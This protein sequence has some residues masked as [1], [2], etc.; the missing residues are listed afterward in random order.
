MPMKRFLKIFVPIL[1]AVTIVFSIGWY[2]IEYDPSFTRDILLQQARRLEESGNVDAAVWFYHLAYL[3]S[4]NDDSVAIELAEKFQSIGNYSKAEYTLTKAIEDG[5][6]VDLYTALCKIYMEQGKLR[7]AVRLL[8]NVSNPEIKTAL[9]EL[10]PAPPAASAASGSY[11]QYLSV[12]LSAPGCQIYASMGSEYPSMPDDLYTSPITLPGGDTILYAVSVGQNG[13]VSSQ[14]ILTY[15]IT[16]VIEEVSFQDPF[17]EFAVRQQL[18][19]TDGRALYSNELLSITELEIPSDA[20]SCS[21]LKWL[22]NLRKLTLLDCA[23]TDLAPV[24]SLSQLETLVITG[25]SLSSA[26]LKQIAQLSSLESLT[27]SGCGVSTIEALAGLTGLTYLDLSGNTIRNLSA[28]RNMTALKELYL[29][30]NAL[31]SLTDLAGLS[32]LQILDVAYNSLSS[33]APLASLTGL[34]GLDVS[35]N[36]L[37]KLEGIGALTNLTAFTASHNNL[38]EVDVLKSCKNLQTVDLSYNTL[39]NI[40]ALANLKALVELDFS[41]NEVK[42][43]PKFQSDCGLVT[44]DGSYN[45]LSSLNP[46]SVL[47]SL[48]TITMDYN[49]GISNIDM[50]RYCGSL[51]RVDVYGSKVR[52][53]SKLTQKG[54]LVNYTPI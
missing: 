43:L 34:T 7:D 23:V 44:I 51:Q 14:T 5:G 38:V 21:D 8:D 42:T 17:V 3:Q 9:D 1:M 27:L 24:S 33:T 53:V 32:S 37:M 16:D 31:I 49:A 48:T 19:I 4:K 41:H 28:L 26:H 15:H 35:G 25:A 52:D 18:Q 6:G 11:N 22:P 54:I 20:A 2:L 29:R 46:L 39:L 50:L 30:S 36:S 40:D 45:L 13:L 47:Q 10:R 12:I